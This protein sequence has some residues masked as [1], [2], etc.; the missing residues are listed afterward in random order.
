MKIGMAIGPEC[1][2]IH[3]NAMKEED[4]SMQMHDKEVQVCV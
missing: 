1:A 4:E 2:G 3:I